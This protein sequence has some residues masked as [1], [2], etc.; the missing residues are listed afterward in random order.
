MW[1]PPY[2]PTERSPT[3]VASLLSP[4]GW[5]RAGAAVGGFLGRAVHDFTNALLASS[6]LHVL[7]VFGL[8]YVPPVN[9]R[10]FDNPNPP[11]EVV[12]VNKR[13]Q[14][15]P[16]KP[17][18]LAQANLDGG[19]DV[20][21]ARVASSPLP[22]SEA[23]SPASQARELNHRVEA[24]ER[25]AQALMQRLKSEYK[26]PE[27]RPQPPA[28]PRPPTPVQAQAELTERSM[29]MARLAARIDQ[30]WDQ[31]QKRPRRMYVGARAQEFTF[32]QYV[33]DWRIKVERV[34]NLNYPE[35][36][37]RNQLYGSLVITVSINSDG[38]VES[39]QIDRSSGSKVLDAAAVKIVEMSAPF[40]RFSA[41]MSKRVDILG[42]TRTWTFT[43][44]DQ[45]TSSQ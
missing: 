33:E 2:P 35:A 17:D 23:D 28:E 7:I 34:G 16:L 43:R 1:K 4:T 24:L 44:S 31:Y 27:T 21:E 32:A 42:I 10:L 6:L 45:L 29:E 30:Q 41:E 8:E 20:E 5:A 13:S 36:A 39:I 11:L 18:V 26:V 25:E 37:R 12:L 38:T 19:G 40:A 9:P 3:G 14:D 15:K 22:A